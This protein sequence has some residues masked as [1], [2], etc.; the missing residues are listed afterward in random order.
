MCNADHFVDQGYIVYFTDQ[1]ARGRSVY[2]A[3]HQ[4]KQIVGTAAGSERN[5]T[6]IAELGTWPQAKL[7]TQGQ[8]E[9]PNRG[10]R[11]HPVFGE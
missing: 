3:Q 9:G 5:N 8:G 6:A 1:P 2:S 10:K 11:G 4:G 7:H